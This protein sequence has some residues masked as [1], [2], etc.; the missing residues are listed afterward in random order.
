LATGKRG[1]DT[2]LRILLYFGDLLS[3]Y[4]DFRIK[5][6]LKIWLLWCIYF[7]HKKFFVSVSL[8]CFGHQKLKIHPCSPTNPKNK[9]FLKYIYIYKSLQVWSPSLCFSFSKILLA[10]Q[11]GATHLDFAK[12]AVLAITFGFHQTS[13]QSFSFQFCEVKWI[14]WKSS[15]R[16]L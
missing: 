11:N 2:N 3:K 7:F 15:K 9:F 13:N 8:D 10:R 14:G 4:G 5:T 12:N 16:G 1:K 6:I